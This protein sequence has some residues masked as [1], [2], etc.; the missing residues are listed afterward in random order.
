MKKLLH[1]KNIL[2]KSTG[3]SPFV[4][5]DAETGILEIAGRAI[6]EDSAAFFEPLSAWLDEYL[7]SP[8][9]KTV[10]TFKMYYFNTST[11]KWI[12]NLL[13]KFNN[14]LDKNIDFEVLWFWEDEDSLEYGQEV[15]ELL[16]FPITFVETELDL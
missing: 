14:V 16:N 15:G 5:F 10:L 2:V 4:S 1:M 7:L 8:A 11:S 6:P 9:P 3:K 13:K 12:L